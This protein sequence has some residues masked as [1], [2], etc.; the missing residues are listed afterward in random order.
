[1]ATT[2]TC[3]LPNAKTLKVVSEIPRKVCSANLPAACN[4]DDHSL[5]IC[6]HEYNRRHLV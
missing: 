5:E 3:V 1:M 4:N 2:G 6:A